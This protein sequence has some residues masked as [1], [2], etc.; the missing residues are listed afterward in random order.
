MLMCPYCHTVV[1]GDYQF[2]PECGRPLATGEVVVGGGGEGKSKKKLAGIIVACIVAVIV[3]AVIAT[4]T[5]TYTLST[6]VSPSGA[7]FILPSRGDY[8]SGTQV[9]LTAYPTSGYAFDRW[10]GSMYDTT[11]TITITM[12]SDASLT[13]HFEAI[14]TTPSDD[15]GLPEVLFADD[16][17]DEVGT[18]DTFS[19]EGG[20]AFYMNDWL[21]LVNQFAG[22]FAT[23]SVAHR[24][25]TDFVLEVETKLVGGTDNNWHHVACRYRDEDNYY[26]FSISADGFYEIGK[27]VNGSPTD[28][29]EI[30]YSSHIHQGQGVTNLMHVECIGNTLS[31]SVN[32]HLLWEG[33][34]ATF[35]G[36]DIGLGAT[37]LEASFTEIA[38]D[39][40]RVTKPSETVPTV[41]QVLF[42]DDFS[43]EGSGWVT[44]DEY[45]GRV[46]YT[47]ECLYV[48]D[49]T[50]LEGGMYGECQRYFTDFV[51]EVET[52]LIGGTDFNWH[53]VA[54][55]FQD[56]NNYYGF[57]ISADGYYCIVKFVDGNEVPLTG[58]AGIYSSYIHHGQG[59]S[60]LIH[61][62][63][64]GSSLS[65]SVNGHLLRQVADTTF[66]GGDIALAAE[67]Q[68]GTY[69]EVAFDNVVVREP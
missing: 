60:N 22:P 45:D 36:G 51:L 15:Q 62:E 53:S 43:D 27:W 58:Q 12:D 35:G 19:D 26:D 65:L 5:P 42:L 67:A 47:N 6:S 54:C 29:V 59:V 24:Y 2:C 69:T 68:A 37:S 20:S 63:C 64:I 23:T 9:A 28:L 14:P 46:A 11:P 8:D 18:W 50:T 17:N 3:I 49:H 1:S 52:W 44:Y 61:I 56:E 48:K 25:F 7:G 10:S 55:R 16:F 33:A 66:T 21:H 4:R 30:T 40:I 38:F 34:D 32:G 31:L 41:P 13:A 39:N 57:G